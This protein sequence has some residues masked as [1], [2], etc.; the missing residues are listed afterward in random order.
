MTASEIA[1]TV[2][3]WSCDFC[4]YRVCCFPVCKRELGFDMYLLAVDMLETGDNPLI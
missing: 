3:I 1:N 4:K 2:Y